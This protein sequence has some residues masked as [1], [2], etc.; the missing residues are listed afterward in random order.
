VR[1]RELRTQRLTK[2]HQLLGNARQRRSNSRSQSAC[3]CCF[4]CLAA[5]AA[6]SRCITAPTAAVHHFKCL[7]QVLLQAALQLQQ[8]LPGCSA[9]L[10]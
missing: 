8:L 2:R 5:A 7:L 9:G 3:C 6:A 10:L 1:Q 4:G